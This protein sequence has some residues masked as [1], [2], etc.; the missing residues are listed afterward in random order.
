MLFLH[1][2]S[3][4][5]FQTVV[6]APTIFKWSTSIIYLR[7]FFYHFLLNYFNLNTFVNCDNYSEKHENKIKSIIHY[8]ERISSSTPVGNVSIERKVLAVDHNFKYIPYLKTESC[9]RTTRLLS[10]ICCGL[11]WKWNLSVTWFKGIRKLSSSKSLHL[12]ARSEETHRNRIITKKNYSN[13]SVLCVFLYVIVK[14]FVL[15]LSV[16]YCF[17]F[18]FK[19]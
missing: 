15:I 2:L 5:F 19:D 14:C 16:G 11:G 17:Y 10:Q 3:F 18:H 8:F 12:I 4:V 1:A 9:S 6:E 7:I 13:L